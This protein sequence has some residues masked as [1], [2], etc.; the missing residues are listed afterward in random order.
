[1]VLLRPYLWGEAGREVEVERRSVSWLQWGG[2][3]SSRQVL[4]SLDPRRM[5]TSLHHFP[6]H[7]PLEV[8]VYIY[9]SARSFSQGREAVVPHSWK[10]LRK[11]TFTVVTFLEPLATYQYRESFI[12]MYY[13]WAWESIIDDAYLSAH[14]TYA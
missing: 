3:P 5:D 9:Y 7:S 10:C 11:I 12:T 1:M 2:P 13:L 14:P 4:E 8:R 6:Q